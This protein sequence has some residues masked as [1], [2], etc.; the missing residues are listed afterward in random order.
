M[1]SK[2]GSISTSGGTLECFTLV[3]CGQSEG[4]LGIFDDVLLVLV[5][6]DRICSSLFILLFVP[7][8]PFC[9]FSMLL[10]LISEFCIRSNKKES[11]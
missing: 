10:S 8:Y 11:S 2:T 3:F 1:V 6:G 4:L 7:F 5:M 9:T